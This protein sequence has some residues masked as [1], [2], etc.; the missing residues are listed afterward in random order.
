MD[1]KGYHYVLDI[2]LNEVTFLK[3]ENQLKEFFTEV[4]SKTK[5]NVI[6]FLS[7]K[8]TIEGEGVTGVFLLSE[9]HLSYHTYPESK[10]ISIDI[11]TCGDKCFSVVQEIESRLHSAAKIVVRYI[12]RGGHISAFKNNILCTE[13]DKVN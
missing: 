13:A 8:F 3:N 6:G 9:S 12:E 2:V 4:L 10:Y 1:N 7:H 11:Y 5:F